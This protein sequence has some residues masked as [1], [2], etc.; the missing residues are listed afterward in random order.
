MARPAVKEVKLKS[1]FY[2]EVSSSS[3]QKGVKIR[4]DS[5]EQIQSTMRYY[6]S[7]Y[8]VRYLGEI[9]KGKVVAK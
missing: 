6:E 9:K 7:S 2:I 5:Y 1:G 8:H 3:S 4:R